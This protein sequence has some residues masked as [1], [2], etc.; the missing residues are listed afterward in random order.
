M[1]TLGY[2]THFIIDGFNASRKT[3]E[4]ESAI[5]SLLTT[6]AHTLETSK[7][8]KK[9]FFSV[10]ESHQGI[11]AYYAQSESFVILHTFPELES[12]SLSIFSR[13]DVNSQDLLAALRTT[14][15]IRRFESHMSNH[16]RT[17]S[18]DSALRKRAILGDRAY[19]ATRLAESPLF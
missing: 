19:T 12:L 15:A 2:G 13:H 16:S 6:I 3:L 8:E 17:L 10:D 4:D 5:E 7:S 1:E 9:D 11:S 18:A 14:F